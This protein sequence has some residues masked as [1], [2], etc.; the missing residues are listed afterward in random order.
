MPLLPFRFSLPWS[1][2]LTPC[3]VIV[4]SQAVGPS[5]HKET[6][7]R[8]F[9]SSAILVLPHPSRELVRRSVA[10]VPRPVF[11]RLAAASIF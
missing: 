11:V 6:L 7:H 3:P 9:P 1:E 10:K 5:Y 4:E 2:P 8:F